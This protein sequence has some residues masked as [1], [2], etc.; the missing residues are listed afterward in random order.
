MA[1]QAN[2][3]ALCIGAITAGADGNVYSIILPDGHSTWMSGLGVYY[4]DGKCSENVGIIPDIQVRKSV[5]D[6][7]QG[8]DEIL[9]RAIE[10]VEN[11]H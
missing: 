6:F 8:K 5:E 7:R 11:G 10:Y 2:P 9:L 4:P 1:L 3:K